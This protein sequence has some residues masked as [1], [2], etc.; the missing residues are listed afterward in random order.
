MTESK[1]P[2]PATKENDVAAKVSSNKKTSKK[3]DV[4]PGTTKTSLPPT[5]TNH[6]SKLAIFA[7]LIAIAAP[8]GHY[9]WQQQLDQQ[10]SQSLT[11]TINTENDA[12]LKRYNNQMQQALTRQQHTFTQKLQQITENIQATSQEKIIALETTVQQLEQAIKQ[13]QPSDWLL[14]EAEYLI[15]IAARTVWLEH[16]TK[17]AIGLLKDADA[18][19]NELNDPNYLPVRETIHQDITLLSQMPTLDTDEVILTLM[20]MSKQVNALP[21]AMENLNET[22]EADTHLNLSDDIQ[23]WQTNLAKTWQKFIND[24]IKVRHRT[25]AIEPLMSP[26][27]QENLKQNLSLKIQQAIWSVSERK[28][29]L[30]QQSL[31]D[32]QQWVNDY[33]DLEN[34]LNQQVINTLIN[35]QKKQINFDFPSDLSSLNAIRATLKNQQ[36]RPITSLDT[37]NSDAKVELPK[38]VEATSEKPVKLPN[39][40]KEQEKSEG[41]I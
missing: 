28:G 40:E 19:L 26:K 14:H 18:R 31:Q 8:A 37:D 11:N 10:L 34:T 39:T 9:Y 41:T 21:L 15:R 16:D 6:V 4:K 25:G 23:D 27:Q 22:T 20:A 2:L 12:A 7:L 32:I 35:L 30:Y 38:A 1:T 13:Q 29:K 24:F 5:S 3:I 33:F 17:A 36:N